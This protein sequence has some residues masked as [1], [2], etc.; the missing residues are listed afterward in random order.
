[1]LHASPEHCVLCMV[2][3]GE[4]WCPRGE[5]E[6][7]GTEGFGG[8]ETEEPR[9]SA[10]NK[11]NPRS[12]L[13]GR[14]AY[15]RGP[16]PGSSL[17]L[18]QCGATL[19]PCGALQLGLHRAFAHGGLPACILLSRLCPSNFLSSFWS[20][21]LGKPSQTPRLAHRGHAPPLGP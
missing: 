3:R 6:A 20:H 19:E 14:V 16:I 8:R 9:A 18:W 17:G 21:F 11:A 7:V 4:W 15:G 5:A 1:M 13:E 12:F 2:V 10:P